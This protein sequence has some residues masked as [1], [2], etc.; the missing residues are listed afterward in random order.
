MEL[1]QINTLNHEISVNTDLN[2]SLAPPSPWV[3]RSSISKSLSNRLAIEISCVNR[4]S[5]WDFSL[6][7]S[8]VFC[9]DDDNN[10]ND[11]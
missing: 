5:F 9:S 11:D 4:A 7:V 10:N 1:M 8:P 3:V 6:S 2:L